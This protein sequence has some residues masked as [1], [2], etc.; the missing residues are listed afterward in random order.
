MLPGTPSC[1]LT[2]AHSLLA[3][4]AHLQHAAPTHFVQQQLPRPAGPSLCTR[5]GSGACVCRAV[6][7]RG[8]GPGECLRNGRCS[9]VKGGKHS[10]GLLSRGDAPG[11]AQ[12][13]LRGHSP[14]PCGTWF[15]DFL[16]AVFA[17]GGLP[18]RASGHLSVLHLCDR[19][20][21]GAGGLPLCTCG[22]L[23][24]R[25]GVLQGEVAHGCHREPALGTAE[26][27]PGPHRGCGCPWQ[28][29]AATRAPTWGRAGAPVSSALGL[30]DILLGAQQQSPPS[31][32]PPCSCCPPQALIVVYAFRFPHLLNPQI[33]RS[34]HRRLHRQ[35]ILQIVLRGP[36]LCFLAAIFSLLFYPVVSG[37]GERLPPPRGR[38][39][40]NSTLNRALSTR[41]WSLAPHSHA[42][43]KARP[44]RRAPPDSAVAPHG[45]GI[46]CCLPLLPHSPGLP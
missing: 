41:L 46:S 11:T 37:G 33:G 17:D 40:R 12:P 14:E 16:A 4:Q 44:Q 10:L 35:R 43:L 24:A 28:G 9:S 31:E 29:G 21:G 25:W 5:T 13:S 19:H 39:H 32:G 34:A 18:C 38:A 45:V 8:P 15:S 36:A 42:G 22:P 23:S 7:P 3:T 30:W 20:R 6:R 2:L 26:W 1:C 27:A